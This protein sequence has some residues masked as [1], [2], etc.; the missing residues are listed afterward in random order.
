MALKTVAVN[1]KWMVKILL[2]RKYLFFLL[3]IC[4]IGAVLRFFGLTV[5]SL[6]LDELQS[7][8]TANPANSFQEINKIC[9]ASYDP[10]PTTF[11]YLLNIWF[12]VFGY[13]EL[14]ARLFPTLFGIAS[15]PVMFLLGKRL[16]GRRAG[17]F[18][19]LMTAINYFNIFYS[20]EVRSYSLL[21]FFA[22][23]SY[24]AFCSV[25]EK[26][27]V[28]AL[29]WYVTCT[30]FLIALHFF[31][32][33]IFLT[34]VL[35]WIALNRK[36]LND[37]RKSLPVIIAFLII[38][39]AFVPLVPQLIEILDWESAGQF[40][41]GDRFFMIF[42][43]NLF[44]G[45]NGV[46]VFAAFLCVLIFVTGVFQARRPLDG[47]KSISSAFIL[48]SWI[49]IPLL[50]AYARSLSGSSALAPRYSIVIL[51]ALL[52]VVSAGAASVRSNILQ[53]GLTILFIAGSLIKLLPDSRFYVENDKDDFR[54]VVQKIV[55]SSTG[56]SQITLY[57]DRNWHL[58]YYFDLSDISPKMID[59]E[60]I[61]DN[62]FKVGKP[63]S[64][65]EILSDSSLV[66]FWVA[67]ANNANL[68]KMKNVS[69]AINSSGYY[70]KLDSFM[71][72]EAF[73][74]HF[75]KKSWKQGIERYYHMNGVRI[76]PD[77]MDLS[78]RQL[79]NKGSERVFA[80]WDGQLFSHP[81]RMKKGNY[82]LT[83]NCYGTTA[84]DTLAQVSMHINNNEMG[85]FV[86]SKEY[87]SKEFHF[88]LETD[89][90]VKIALKLENDL[91]D[92]I[93][94]EDR[95]LFVKSIVLKQNK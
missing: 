79:I 82:V 48:F 50:I 60:G 65:Q 28:K 73:A 5:H 51:P 61:S 44:F 54:G 76:G 12:R 40:F 43:F 38:L 52:I 62:R 36:Q 41:D 69:S 53:F 70:L 6:W 2:E 29:V 3:G 11:Y 68:E 33:L 24:L 57:S 31:A 8:V 64:T 86:S 93:T 18:A 30:F 21:F 84:H 95:N 55:S 81:L 74:D 42:Y 9:K 58:K 46:V 35:I 75:L 71:G 4:A 89:T 27:N 32:L 10:S 92:P 59:V 67:S 90:I 34:Q 7:V 22:A 83:I 26:G 88:K 20:V 56:I 78:D 91:Y 17:I 49:I 80:L 85:R 94:E 25:L 72:R 15:I 37:F 19:A 14:S 23:L 77:S 87:E 66:D 39:L 45:M 13:S 47:V 63:R 1:F 16:F